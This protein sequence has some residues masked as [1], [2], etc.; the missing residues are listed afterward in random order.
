M[1]GS[2]PPR[3]HD[4]SQWAWHRQRLQYLRERLLDDSGIQ[5][6]EVSETLEPHSM[7]IADSATDEF[8]HDLALSLLTHEQDALHEL[9]AALRRIQE[10]CY[11]ICEE[12][13]Q[14]IP[15]SRLRAVPWTRHTR[16]VEERLE[17]EGTVSRLHM[18]AVTSLQGPAPGGLPQIDEP[19][20][21]ELL[22]REVVRRE[23]VADIETIEC[24]TDTGAASPQ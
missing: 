13:G 23:R 22:S 11:G 12:T 24:G 18:G 9:N 15:A 5:M 20:E 14:P 21:E 4:P 2:I 1:T 10:G 16:E 3:T 8:D 6:A 17:R 7:D 19:E